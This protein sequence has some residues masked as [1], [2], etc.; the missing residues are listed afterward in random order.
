VISNKSVLVQQINT[1]IREKWCQ[2]SPEALLQPGKPESIKATPDV[3]DKSYFPFI[4][5]IIS[6]RKLEKR[7]EDLEGQNDHLFY[8]INFLIEKLPDLVLSILHN[9]GETIATAPVQD[10]KDG[11]EDPCTHRWRVKNASP[12]CVTR[13]EQEVLD[14]LVKGFCAKEIAHSLFISET[15]VITHKK[16][17]KEKF[18][19]KNTVEL[20][21]KHFDSLEK[22]R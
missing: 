12:P 18:N 9:E 4:T 17:L 19:A 7:I 21:S 13:R 6:N 3:V 20:I 15:T 14:L 10:D 1:A 22:R 8:F 5:Q 16:N 11:T 2:I